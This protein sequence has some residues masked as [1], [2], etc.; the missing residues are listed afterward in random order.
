MK[1]TAVSLL[2]MNENYVQA[3]WSLPSTDIQAIAIYRK[4]ASDSNK[5]YIECVS[6]PWSVVENGELKRDTSVYQEEYAAILF[7]T[8]DLFA[9][10]NK[11]LNAAKENWSGVLY[12]L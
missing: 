3:A 5:F 11:D 8:M 7:A 6:G 9:E 10:I 4:P 2:E 1:I 12:D